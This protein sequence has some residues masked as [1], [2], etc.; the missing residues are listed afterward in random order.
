MEKSAILHQSESRF[1]F[2]LDSHRALV[3]LRTKREDTIAKISVIWNSGHRFWKE[4]KRSSMTL[5]RRDGLFDYY[6][7]IL[8]GQPGF[9]YLFEITDGDG[10]IWYYNESGFDTQFRLEDSFKDNFT[11]TYPNENDIVK[12]NP[13]FEGRVFYQI[14]PERF[15]KSTNKTYT[16]Y[17]DQEWDTEE[18]DNLKFMGGDLMGITQKLPYLKELGIGAIYMTPI[19]P[20][21]SAHKYDIDDYFDVDKMFGSLEDLKTLVNTAHSMDIKIM[22][23]LV[24]NHSSYYNPMFQDVVKNGRKSQYY[25]W[26]FID[27][28]KPDKDQLNYLTFADVWMMPKLNTNHPQVQAY[29]TSVAAF[30]MEHYHVDGFRL[31]V[32]FDVSHDFWRYFK[33]TLKKIDPNV[34]IVG[35]CWQ[36]SESFLGNDQW[37]S[38]MNYPFLYACQRFIASD[39]YTPG[40]FADYLNGVL[41]RYKDGTNR[42]MLNLLDSHDIERFYNTVH[43]DKDLQLMAIAALMFY[44]GNPMIYYGDEI[45]MDGKNDPYNRKGMRW[46]SAEFD[47]EGH[48]MIRKLL[49]LRQEP[50]LQKGDIRIFEKNG[51]VYFRR[52]LN[53]QEMSLVLNR[54]GADRPV[55]G[56]WILANRAENGTVKDKGFVVLG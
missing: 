6:E 44:Q 13:A 56:K 2:P 8:D 15:A 22:M 43:F 4:Q 54:S 23:D 45:F 37:D 34:F 52:I 5:E 31:D 29:L 14:F 30:Y 32:A 17:I 39:R 28:D 9:S 48:R 49:A 1:S 41:M 20:S 40:D 51:L 19:H 7:C 24:F 21:V 12:P 50:I 46:N 10:R 33:T 42:M 53:G 26:Y 18:P 36:N 16:D 55:E 38:V 27:G 35:E 47:G 11:T 3:R 25:D